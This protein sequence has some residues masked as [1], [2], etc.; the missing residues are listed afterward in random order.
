MWRD[1]TFFVAR[2]G[3]AQFPMPGRGHNRKPEMDTFSAAAGKTKLTLPAHHPALCGVECTYVVK[4][5]YT[6]II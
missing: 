1:K 3:S 4:F 5:S 6:Y 2:F